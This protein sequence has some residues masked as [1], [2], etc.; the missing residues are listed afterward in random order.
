MPKDGLYPDPSKR[1]VRRYWSGT[2]WTE[3]VDNFG[4]EYTDI[5]QQS[6]PPPPDESLIPIEKVTFD[7]LPLHQRTAIARRIG[8]PFA[9]VI[10]GIAAWF[11]LFGW[12]LLASVVYCIFAFIV[13]QIALRGV[14]MTNRQRIN[15]IADLVAVIPA[16]AVLW[17]PLHSVGFHPHG[18]W[19]N[20]CW[21][22]TD[23]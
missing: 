19:S 7:S 3:R 12:A 14:G 11:G 6:F 17:P 20:I 18:G 1:Y 21:V 15:V 5:V 16:A 10:Y 23:C 9:L 8:M 13:L 2:E 22:I 4:D